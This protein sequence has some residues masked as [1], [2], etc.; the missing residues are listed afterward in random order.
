M[1]VILLKDIK[2]VGQKGDLINTSDGY[3]RN[4]LIPRKFAEEATQGNIRIVNQRKEA[5]RRKKLEETEKA[6]AI[7]KSLKGQ[8]IHI[9]AKTGENG[10]L[11]GSITGK[12]IQDALL[13]QFK[14]E[15]DRKKISA[16]NIKQLGTYS[17]DIRLYPEITTTMKL[18][19]TEQQ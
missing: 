10:R 15:V 14:I 13:K 6:Q 5:E 12:D 16:D 7:A 19:I 3:A 17:I 18:I 9:F 8:E 1:K 2:G 4:Y 11:F